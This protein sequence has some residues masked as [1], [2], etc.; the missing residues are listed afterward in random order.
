MTDLSEFVT[1]NNTTLTTDSRRVAKHFSKRHDNVLQAFDRLDCSTEYRLLNFQATMEAVPGPKGSTRQERVI[2]MTKNG[3]MFLVMGFRGKKAADIKEAYINAFDAMAEQLQQIGLSLWEQRL[4][5]EK[6][7]ATTF[8]WASFGSRLMTDRKRELPS[9][10]N[11]RER[12]EHEM[13][14][15]LFIGLPHEGPGALN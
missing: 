15:A 7:D 4:Q 12:L 8:M 9:I 10:R 11:D 13:Q 6:R 1:L 3:F 14:P 2:R 5:L